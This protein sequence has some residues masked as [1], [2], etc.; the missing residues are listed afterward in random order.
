MIAVLK[1][2][3]AYDSLK[4]AEMKNNPKS[5]TII[6]CALELLNAQGDHGVTMR[7]VAQCADMSLSNVQYYFKNKDEL[8]TA[9]AN[10]YF[11]N[12]LD[13]IRQLPVLADGDNL[14]PELAQMLRGFL[15]HGLEVSEMCRIFREYWAIATRNDVIEEYLRKYYSDLAD[16]L[17]EKLRPA[18]PSPKALSSA[19]SVIIP[20]VEGYSITAH[21]LPKDFDAVTELLTSTVMSLMNND[22]NE[23]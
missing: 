2:V 11:E 13:E 8:L 16:I 5:E 22:H 17:T 7:K 12:C 4:R 14:R 1:H 6:D 10:R 9:L 18:S 21:S 23:L 19:V 15:T 20:F 3:N